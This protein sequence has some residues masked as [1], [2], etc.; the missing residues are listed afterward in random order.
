MATVHELYNE[1]EK[2][3]D[4]GKNEEAIAKLTEL[5]QQDETFV[6]A[7][8]AL[9]VLYGNVGKPEDAVR[10]GQRACELEPAEPFNYTAMSITYRKAFQATNDQK[11]IQ[12][13]EEAMMKAQTCK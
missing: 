5:L 7:H 10:H 12:L 9:A 8:M 2:L 4:D 1:S 3:K 11:Y 13:A 6:L